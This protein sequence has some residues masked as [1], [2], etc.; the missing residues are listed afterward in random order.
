MR[1]CGD[2]VVGLGHGGASYAPPVAFCNA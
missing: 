2:N 1:R